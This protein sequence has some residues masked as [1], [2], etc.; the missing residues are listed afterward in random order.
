MGEIIKFLFVTDMYAIFATLLAFFLGVWLFKRQIVSA[1][2]KSNSLKPVTIHRGIPIYVISNPWQ[3]KN[4]IL[5]LYKL[6]NFDNSKVGC[7][8]KQVEFKQKL[9]IGMDCEWKPRNKNENSNENK[10]ALLQLAT[11]KIGMLIQMIPLNEK[12]IPLGFLC[13]C[14][15]VCFLRSFAKLRKKFLV[16]PNSF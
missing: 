9:I 12:G 13:F 6:H 11:N 8:G 10:V 4:A 1:F 14:V 3:C 7:Q 16:L 15:C 5:K 2:M